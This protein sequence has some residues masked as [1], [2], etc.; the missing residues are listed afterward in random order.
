LHFIRSL[1]RAKRGI[2][3]FASAVPCN[4]C[5]VLLCTPHSLGFAR[6]ASGAFYEVAHFHPDLKLLRDHH[7]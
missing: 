3:E 5:D 2:S 6:L 7:E 4:H 1:F